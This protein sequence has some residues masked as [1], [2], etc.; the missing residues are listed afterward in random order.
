M[1]KGIPEIL[2]PELLKVLMEMGHGDELLLCDGNYPKFGC[3][4]NCIRMDGHGIP[5]ILDAI[6]KFFPLDEY[7]ENPTMFMAV[8]PNDPYKP[9]I[10]PKY[11]EI[12]KKYEEKGL[13][14]IALQKPEFYARGQQCYCCIATS[15]KALYANVII[16]K[17]VVKE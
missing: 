5:E 6:L 8:L 11:E 16:R 3:P 14:Q 17:G 4:E 7:V 9:V 1:L 15:E 10:W 12:G 13:R 2:S